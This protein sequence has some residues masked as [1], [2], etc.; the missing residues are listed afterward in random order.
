MQ[1]IL[2]ILL[3]LAAAF[4]LYPLAMIVWANKKCPPRQSRNPFS[5]RHE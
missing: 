5:R 1:I 4:G 3:I 2:P